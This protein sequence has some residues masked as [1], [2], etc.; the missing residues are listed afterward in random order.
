MIAIDKERAISILQDLVRI[1]SV[2]P[3]LVPG[4][5]GEAACANYIA[6]LMHS[7][8]LD[9]IDREL[10]PGRHN[11]TG[12]LRG[13]GGGRTLLFNGHMDTVSIAGMSEPFS[14]EVRDGR[15]YGRGAFDM[16]GSLAATLVATH[17]IIQSGVK[18]R[19][20]VVFT[21]V[22]DEEYASIG[23]EGIVADIESGALPRP[24]GAVNTEPTY[25][26]LGIAHKGFVWLEV[27]TLGVAAHGS[28]PDLGVDAIVQMGKVLV[29]IEAR[30]A[31][32]TAGARH[33]LL[34]PGS[35]HASLIGGGRARVGS[36]VNGR[37]AGQQRVRLGRA[38]VI[39]QRGEQRVQRGGNRAGLVA[40]GSKA[41]GVVVEPADQV[42]AL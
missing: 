8:G 39:T 1:D 27:E 30:Q 26:K 33:A 29:Q 25:L 35:V 40:R 16:K 15:L 24:D 12:V 21:Y 41:N 2:N 36:C 9:V 31:R 37:R 38:A 32:L 5:A 6:E 42:V 23:T 3:S 14:G 11:T 34:G 17:A 4:A 22:A 28:R 20:D 10:T 13:S 7:W 19:G 18:L